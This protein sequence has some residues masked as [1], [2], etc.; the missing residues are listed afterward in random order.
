MSL[1]SEDLGAFIESQLENQ[2]LFLRI[3]NRNLV[4]SKCNQVHRFWQRLIFSCNQRTLPA[5]LYL[6]HHSFTQGS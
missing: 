5:I 6:V 1:P 2:N 3:V 4:F